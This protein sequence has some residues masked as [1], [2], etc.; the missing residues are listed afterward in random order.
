MKNFETLE[1]FSSCGMT[2]KYEF[3]PKPRF[4]ESFNCVFAQAK[5]KDILF[6]TTYGVH[7]H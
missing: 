4:L 6:K 3:W 7:L 2:T 5:T 1:I